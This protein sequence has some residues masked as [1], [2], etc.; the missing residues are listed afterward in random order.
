MTRQAKCP[1]CAKPTELGRNNKWRPFCCERCRLIDLGAWMDE[2][3]SI[4]SEEAVFTNEI[5]NT[6]PLKH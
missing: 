3:R 4:P 2:S 5:E 1:T 6:E